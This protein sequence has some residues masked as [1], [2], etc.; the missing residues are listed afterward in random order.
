MSTKRK[1]IWVVLHLYEDRY[2][3]ELTFS[4]RE[5]LEEL[6][7]ESELGRGFRQIVYS[8]SVPSD[9]EVYD[10]VPDNY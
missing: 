5:L 7:P 9:Y 4:S 8:K 10:Y 6:C 1:T 2:H 3:G